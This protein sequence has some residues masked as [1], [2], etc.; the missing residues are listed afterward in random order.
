MEF[1]S[2]GGA[3]GSYDDTALTNLVN[4]N[5]YAIAGPHPN[6]T[7]Q[8]AAGESHTGITT[9]NAIGGT[10][11][12]TTFDIACSSRPNW[13]NWPDWSAGNCWK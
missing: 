12:G 10:V 2:L 13:S 4:A 1:T 3:G 8:D 7:V 11:T 9:I 6:I 5:T